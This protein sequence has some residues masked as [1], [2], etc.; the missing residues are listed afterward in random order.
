MVNK[1]MHYFLCSLWTAIQMY[2]VTK[3]VNEYYNILNDN[4]QI[5]IMKYKWFNFKI[6]LMGQ[7]KWENRQFEYCLFPTPPHSKH[8]KDR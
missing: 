7:D 6:L 1:V 5:F 4:D 8:Y 2:K 3:M